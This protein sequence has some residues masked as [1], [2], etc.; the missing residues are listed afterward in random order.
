VDDAGSNNGVI[1]FPS[2]REMPYNMNIHSCNPD[3]WPHLAWHLPSDARKRAYT[4][5]YW[6]WELP[7]LPRDWETGFA[8][9]D[10]VW[11]ASRFTLAAVAASSPVPVVYV[12]LAVRPP[13]P[14]GLR[15]RSDFN[16]M[17]DDYVVLFAFDAAS[18][19]ARKN[20]LGLIAA[21]QLAFPSERDV[22]L[23]IKSSRAAHFGV[24]QLFSDAAAADPRIILLDEIIPANAM[25][26]LY[27]LADCY[28]SLHRS[29][30]FGLTCA[31][32]LLMGLPV[33]A[34]DYA[35][36]TDFL[37]ESTGYPVRYC[38]TELQQNDGPYHAGQFWA[39]P[40]LQHAAEQLRRV[41]DNRA[42]ARMRAMAG[43]ERIRAQYSA[44]AVGSIIRNRLEI[45]ARFGRL[46]TLDTA[47]GRR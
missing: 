23:I 41:R 36:T 38:L 11:T 30:G 18:G 16:I 6:F 8:F 9:V 39:E 45:L 17:P 2:G 10:E 40:D 46:R 24:L 12:P 35:G 13:T 5:G 44:P 43:A 20:P 25:A 15:F 27:Q 34:T 29:E 42:D 14:A 37:D 19:L 28:A 7:L 4:A 31:E 32:A 1:E 33:L 26:D 47:S 21:F 3:A 22:K